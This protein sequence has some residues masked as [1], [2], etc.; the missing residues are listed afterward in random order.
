VISNN[1]ASL[2]ADHRAD[3][4]EQ[5]ARAIN[6]AKRF[7]SSD[8][9]HLQDT[10]GWLLH[11]SGD[12]QAGSTYVLKAAEALAANPLVQYH[13]GVILDAL[14]QRSQARARLL[15]ALELGEQ[16]PFARADAARAQ[17]ARIEVG[18]AAAETEGGGS[19]TQ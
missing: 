9:P 2:L 6:I 5:L 15:R 13:A 17:L 11:L 18:D 3:D 14:G 16:V 19:T 4:P 7:R 12:S 8:Q 10:Y 1:F